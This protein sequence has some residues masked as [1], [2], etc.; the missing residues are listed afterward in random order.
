MTL[1]LCALA[2][3]CPARGGHAIP[4]PPPRG[5]EAVVVMHVSELPNFPVWLCIHSHE[6]AWNDR[7]D[8]YWGG[9]QMDRG[10]MEAYGPD[11]I[12][13]HGGGWADTWTPAEQIEVAQ[14]AYLKRGY[15]PWPQ[16][17]HMCGVY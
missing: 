16:T 6:A 9:L 1:L 8:P 3:G 11:M 4:V 14:R 2:L 7:G 10:F 15:E 5:G 12:R 13:L 17:A